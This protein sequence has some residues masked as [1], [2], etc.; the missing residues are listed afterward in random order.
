[1]RAK[2]QKI[3]IAVVAI[4]VL[5]IGISFIIPTYANS[6]NDFLAVCVNEYGTHD[7]VFLKVS[8]KTTGADLEK[9]IAKSLGRDVSPEDI[10]L[11][12]LAWSTVM[13]KFPDE[14]NVRDYQLENIFYVV[15]PLPMG[16]VYKNG[17]IIDFGEGASI[18]AKYLDDNDCNDQYFSGENAIACKGCETICGT[19]YAEIIIGSTTI[20][21]ESKKGKNPKGFRIAHM[22]YDQYGHNFIYGFEVVD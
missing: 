14:A 21:L 19:D 18:Q 3:A 9:Q 2:I 20:C 6:E 22:S 5:G 1:M 12:Y 4:F 8:S 16:A 7:D 11:I 10:V 15:S 17:Q 13:E